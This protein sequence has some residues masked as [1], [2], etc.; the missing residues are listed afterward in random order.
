MTDHAFDPSYAQPDNSDRCVCGQPLSADVHSRTL[1]RGGVLRAVREQ[2]LAVSDALEHDAA[3][4]LFVIDLLTALP[5]WTRDRARTAMHDMR[6]SE[7]KRCG[8]LSTQ[9]RAMIARKAGA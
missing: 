5:G 6:L 8:W 4:G 9:Q 1:D 3:F 7:L 2:R